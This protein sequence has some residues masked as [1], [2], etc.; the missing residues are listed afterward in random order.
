MT[1][2]ADDIKALMQSLQ[3]QTEIEQQHWSQQVIIRFL[4]ISLSNFHHIFS[5]SIF[6]LLLRNVFWWGNF[7][8]VILIY[9]FHFT[10]KVKYY[11][12][13]SFLFFHIMRYFYPD[14]IYS[15]FYLLPN[16]IGLT[17]FFIIIII[18]ILSISLLFLLLCKCKIQYN[19][20]V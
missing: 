19:I 20:L 3:S 10:E 12:I 7:I 11:F 5:I 4:W 6:Y 14:L 8:D 15:N 1:T 2:L 16:F 17:F 13:Y 18:I 9:L